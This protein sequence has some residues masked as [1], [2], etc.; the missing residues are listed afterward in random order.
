MRQSLKRLV[1]ATNETASFFVRRGALR[2]CQFRL[3]SSR[4]VRFHLEE[5]VELPLRRGAAGR[6]LLA[7]DGEAGPIYEGIRAKGFYVS[8]GERDAEVTAAAV[9]V[10]DQSGKLAGAL[11]VSGLRA[12][13]KGDDI[14]AAVRC[15]RQEAGRLSAYFPQHA[16]LPIGIANSTLPAVPRKRHR[17]KAAVRVGGTGI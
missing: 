15:L 9:P 13:F 5:G 2:V 14:K 10:L 8:R 7:F 1:E 11:A 4:A 17:E 12:R 6:V 16:G 3:N